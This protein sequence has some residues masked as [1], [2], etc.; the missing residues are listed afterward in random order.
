MWRLSVWARSTK[1]GAESLASAYEKP[2]PK[3]WCRTWKLP[4]RLSSATATSPQVS[5]AVSRVSARRNHNYFE[6]VN[7]VVVSERASVFVAWKVERER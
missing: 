6:V 4:R 7:R 3:S 1:S 2:W 5:E